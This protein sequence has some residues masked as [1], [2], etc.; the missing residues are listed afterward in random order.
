MI[1]WPR[2]P[3]L[4][5]TLLVIFGLVLEEYVRYLLED[6]SCQGA[7]S[8]YL[9]CILGV[10]L[11]V[12][13]LLIYESIKVGIVGEEILVRSVLINLSYVLLGFLLSA[14]SYKPYQDLTAIEGLEFWSGLVEE[15][16]V[17]KGQYVVA[18]VRLRMIK[19]SEGD[20]V[21]TDPIHVNLY[22]KS[23]EIP[24]SFGDLIGVR[25]RLSRLSPP[26]NPF[27]FDY[28]E[29]LHTQDIYFQCFVDHTSLRILK[30]DFNKSI[31]YYSLKAR[32][33]FSGILRRELESQKLIAIAEALLL[34][35]KKK[36]DKQTKS[37]F[38]KVGVM[39][40][41]AVSGLHVGIIY[42]IFVFLFGYIR[43]NR[44][45]A[46][47]LFIIIIMWGYALLTGLSP[48]VIR[49]TM[50]ISLVLISEVLGR[51]VNIYNSIAVSA[52]LMILFDPDIIYSLGFQLSFLAVLGII[53]VSPS[54]YSIYKPGNKV[55]NFFWSLSCASFSAQLLTAPLAIH[56]FNNFPLLFL[57]SNLLVVPMATLALIS[58][59]ALV[60]M[61][62]IS[63]YIAT[64]VVFISKGL[65]IGIVEIATWIEKLDWSTLEGIYFSLSEMI[66]VY[67][68]MISIFISFHVRRFATVPYFGGLVLMLFTFIFHRQYIKYTTEEF[69]FYSVKDD[70]V[71][72]YFNCGNV[73]TLSNTNDLTQFA[74][75]LNS[76]RIKNGYPKVEKVKP[77]KWLTTH[78]LE[79]A[80]I[81]GQRLVR[82]TD[83]I[84][85]S[86][87]KADIVVLGENAFQSLASLISKMDNCKVIILDNTNDRSYKIRLMEEADSLNIKLIDLGQSAHIMNMNG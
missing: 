81:G 75:H 7:D 13:S 1:N 22:C 58:L 3:F 46:K 72:D 6:D 16:G 42:A 35:L 59:V 33:F 25:G 37:T 8:N 53:Y 9:Y 43:S 23:K 10:L 4:R 71:M 34:G 18:K 70:F 63:S 29:Y 2:F 66:L 69:V 5:F 60:V 67:L 78:D 19:N 84:D 55:T 73:T 20:S 21:F 44:T 32:G 56:Y 49:A 31:R 36:V 39:H 28:R 27:E 76:N 74:Y 14:S 11:I 65:L 51:R 48:S 80:I 68:I 77:T 82:V 38:S 61:G 40:I 50:M 62:A 52:F 85:L 12:W 24:F 45:W 15:E 87:V 26:K 64:P 57:I 83:K 47:N 79:L 30:P 54:I 41:L 17:Q 86:S